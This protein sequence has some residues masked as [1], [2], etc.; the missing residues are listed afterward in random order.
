MRHYQPPPLQTP[1]NGLSVCC[2]RVCVG[3]MSLSRPMFTKTNS[4]KGIWKVL[5]HMLFYL[6][7]NRL[8]FSLCFAV[9]K[10]WLD[11]LFKDNFEN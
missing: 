2:C 9:E 4:Y 6:I 7:L 8:G 10:N 11:N 1:A 3:L 5:P